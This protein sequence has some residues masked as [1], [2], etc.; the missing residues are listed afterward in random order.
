MV[1][2]LN[3]LSAAGAAISDY[4]GTA[5]L[6]L[7]KQQLAN[8][9]QVL[10]DTLATTRETKLQ[11]QAQAF[12]GAQNTQQQAA[13]AG[14]QAQSQAFQGTQ[15]DKEI[16]ARK[17]AATQQQ[18]TEKELETMREHAPTETQKTFDWL[19]INPDGTPKTAGAAPSA[20]STPMP[21]ASTDGGV[22]VPPSGAAP[23]APATGTASAST[24]GS[25]AAPP[26]TPTAAAPALAS[27]GTPATQASNQMPDFA[28]AII[29]KATGQ[30][31]PGS[32]QAD[33]LAIANGV[34]RDPAFKYLPADQ[35]AV[36]TE[37]RW[38]VAT[39]KTT[40]AP[41][42]QLLAN[43]IAGYQ[44]PSIQLNRANPG[45]AETMAAVMAINPNYQAEQYQVMSD[46]MKKFSAGP[47]GDKIRFN[48][49][50][51]Q[52]LA[53]LDQAASALGNQNLGPINQL[54][55]Y[56]STEFGS[57]PPNTFNALKDLV[58]KEVQKAVTGGLGA[59]QERQDLQATLSSARSPEQL[60]AVTQAL[61]SLMVGQLNGLRQQYNQAT[62]NQFNKEGSPFAFDNK[63][64]P[65]TKAALSG[66]QG[67]PAAT[68][69]NASPQSAAQ[70]A[71]ADAPLGGLYGATIGQPSTNQ[72][73]V[74]TPKQPSVGEV[75]QGYSFTGGNPADPNS[76]KPVTH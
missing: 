1:S 75:Q 4:A 22:V 64:L 63:L 68:S 67:G 8:Q 61:R 5:G 29:A 31:I 59:V 56:F 21:A 25:G 32:E 53:V 42:R 48:D 7:Q 73:A 54:K 65:E 60:L 26:A 38:A 23:S 69:A 16:A 2:L 12:T 28:K 57:P 55:N 44:L 51:V 17:I 13:A 62:L 66:G 35:Q 20:T 47:D 27:T 70:K 40:D 39:A 34:A 46:A 14:L 71:L 41:T 37:R 58:G 15:T 45:S 3:G 50:G 36:E 11:G 10:A 43:A 9:S 76:W 18:A 72:P 24:G 49:V 74:A 52:H 30:G 33:R 19:G 6:E